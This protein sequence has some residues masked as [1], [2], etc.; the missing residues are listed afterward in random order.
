MSC[1]LNNEYNLCILQNQTY[2]LPFVIKDDNDV[3]I[4]IT[5]WAFTGSIKEKITDPTPY[6]FFTMSI[7]N[8]VSGSISMYLS[9]Q[10]T[11]LLDNKKYIYDVISTNY[12]VNPPETLRIMQGKVS[13]ELGITQP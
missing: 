9:A 7:D 4:D 2:D 10:T 1:E 11:W 8:A 5:N 12:G 13:V 6:L 3:P